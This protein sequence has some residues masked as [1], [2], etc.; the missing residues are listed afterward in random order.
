[1]NTKNSYTLNLV[2]VPSLVVVHDA[3]N[4]LLGNE[5]S[6]SAVALTGQEATV[7]KGKQHQRALLERSEPVGVPDLCENVG[8]HLSLVNAQVCLTAAEL[9]HNTTDTF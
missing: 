4:K 9:W 5:E 7:V 1:M 6:S 8:L 2:Q 3:P